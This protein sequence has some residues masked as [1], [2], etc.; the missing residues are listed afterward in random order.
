MGATGL[1]GVVYQGTYVSATNYGLND[2]VTYQGSSYISLAIA[3]A[4]NTPGQ[5]PAFWAVLA[6]QGTA[7][8]SGATGATG[9][10]G[11]PGLPG[12]PGAAGAPGPVGATGAT[13][14]NFR[15]AWIVGTGYAAN[16]AVTFGGSTYLAEM[17]NS[18]SEPDLYPQAWTMLAQAGGAGPSG[19]TGAAGA[20][21]TMTVG[22]VTT[23]AAGTQATVTN[24]GTSS[25]A[26]LNFTIPQG[27]A[28]PAGSGGSGGGAGISGI[29]F[30]SIYHL[31]SSNS[32]TYYSVNNS[33][34][35]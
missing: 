24:T 35:A 23:G 34:G 27:A 7:G 18:S 4:G 20:A 2:A 14:M 19:P 5:S 16:D 21:A 26:V 11:L 32:L 31:A 25:A 22:T 9:A 12:A 15:G 3:N 30:T 29:P 33:A 13:G 1:A 6:A 28:G 10:Q 8:A 17:S